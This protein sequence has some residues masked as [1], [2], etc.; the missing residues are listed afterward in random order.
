MRISNA[1]IICISSY[2]T[3]VERP[4]SPRNVTTAECIEPSLYHE[5][6]LSKV[7]PVISNVKFH[8]MVKIRVYVKPGVD[9]LHIY[10]PLLSILRLIQEALCKAL[11]RTDIDWCMGEHPF[12]PI[13]EILVDQQKYST[14]L[15][16]PKIA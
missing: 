15:D 11:L 14:T 1:E 9:E 2:V 5:L 7:H 4:F 6:S 12:H 3:Y 8:R 13:P 10:L 16:Y